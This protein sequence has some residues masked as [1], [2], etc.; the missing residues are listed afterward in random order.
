[1]FQIMEVGKIVKHTYLAARTKIIPAKKLR[2]QQP[3]ELLKLSQERA[4]ALKK[5]LEDT[6]KDLVNRVVKSIRIPYGC[7]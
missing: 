5:W 6:I 3:T 4:V 1:M 7:I 2:S